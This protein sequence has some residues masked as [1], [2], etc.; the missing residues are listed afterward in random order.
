MFYV[1][2]VYPDA[3]EPSFFPPMRATLLDW[4]RADP[5]DRRE[6]ERNAWIAGLQGTENPF[7]G[8]PS[9]ADRVWGGERASATSGAPSG[10]PPRPPVADRTPEGPVADLRITEIHYDNAGDDVG[11]GVEIRGPDGVSL[12]GWT[13]V[14]VNGSGGGAYRTVSLTA[15]LDGGVAWVPLGGLQNGAP[16]GVALI[17]PTGRTAQ[18]L[19]WEGSFVG[20]DGTS[21]QDIGVAQASDTEPGTSLQLVGDRWTAGRAASPGRLNR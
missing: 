21:F 9:L 18:A 6:R 13:L 11:E 2:A 4:N 8:D 1:A 12:G 10:A 5:P 7:V 16:D 14:L 3:V 19:S 20:A 17:D 15:R